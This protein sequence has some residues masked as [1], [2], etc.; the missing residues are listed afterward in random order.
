MAL[1]ADL[2]KSGGKKQDLTPFVVF[3][4]F[5]IESYLNS[6]GARNIKFWDDLERLPWK[7]KIE[8]LHK[9]TDQK[10][11]WGKEPLQFAA[12]VFKLRDKLAH[13]KAERVVAKDNDL[14]PVDS[15]D[16]VP[17]WYKG[18]NIEWVLEAKGRFRTLM[19]YLGSLFDLHESDHLM[20]SS[21]GMHPD[22]ETDI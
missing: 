11:D 2:E 10:A 6:L 19:V 1:Y 14:V 17:E 5:S 13:G 18:I 7:S 20:L 16:L 12:E 9:T 21:G 4:A 22:E 8:I 3:L 15:R